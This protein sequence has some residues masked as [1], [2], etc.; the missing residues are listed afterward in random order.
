MRSPLVATFFFGVKVRICELWR[1]C[2]SLILSL[3]SLIHKISWEWRRWSRGSVTCTQKPW[4]TTNST[5]LSKF[6]PVL[7]IAE[8]WMTQCHINYWRFCLDELKL[9]NFPK[10]INWQGKS[11]IRE[12]IIKKSLNFGL[13]RQSWRV[14]CQ[15]AII[16]YINSSRSPFLHDTRTSWVP[17][18]MSCRNGVPLK[19]MHNNWLYI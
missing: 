12:Q 7:I 11:R 10:I 18:E 4:Y 1:N 5:C 8:A 6:T 13:S 16:S 2:G 14:Y 17:E 19:I 9:A 3:L 15:S